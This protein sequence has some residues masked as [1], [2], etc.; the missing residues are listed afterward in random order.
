[1]IQ[2]KCHKPF[3]PTASDLH[4]SPQLTPKASPMSPVL[5]HAPHR[6]Q[7]KRAGPTSTLPP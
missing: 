1:L 7:C 4:S 3:A 2:G 6:M 5:I